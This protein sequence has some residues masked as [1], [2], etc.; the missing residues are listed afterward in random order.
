MTYSLSNLNEQQLKRWLEYIPINFLQEPVIRSPKAFSNIPKGFRPN[1]LKHA[2]LVPIYMTEILKHPNCIQAK[3]IEKFINDNLTAIGITDIFD[4]GVT[5]FELVIRITLA[6]IEAEFTVPTDLV[7]VISDSEDS[8]DIIDL[9]AR[10]FDL[11]STKVSEA[12][13]KGRNEGVKVANCVLEQKNQA[14]VKKID[15]IEK[16]LKTITGLHKKESQELQETKNALEDACKKSEEAEKTIV[17]LKGE[18]S[19][20]LE[21]NSKLQISLHDKDARIS[22]LCTQ[23]LEIERLNKDLEST[24]NELNNIQNEIAILQSKCFSD[25]TIREVCIDAIT[26]IQEHGL[27]D[28]EILECARK[29]FPSDVPI[30]TAWETLNAHSVN[31]LGT[32]IQ[33]FT[34][35][36]LSDADIDILDEIENI[37]SMQYLVV[38]CTKVIYFKSLEQKVSKTTISDKFTSERLVNNESA[39]D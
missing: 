23:L 18:H 38:K 22:D 5:G 15:K 7:L 4:S 1:K 19:T 2:Q 28:E 12:I 37:V 11:L 14:L 6:L 35:D 9:A 29:Y 32:V 36:M 26:D 20:F 8:N 33:K 27:T 10:I 39:A 16:E 17:R 34:D 31:L 25:D 30:I 13:T 3:T 21:R 24:T